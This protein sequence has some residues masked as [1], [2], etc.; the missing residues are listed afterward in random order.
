MYAVLDF[1]TRKVPN[2]AM[3]IGGIVG[4]GVVL[5]FGHIVEYAVLHLTA[6]LI[7]LILGCILFRIGALGGADVK[8][9]FTIAI[10]SP[11]IEFASWG[12]PIL[13]GILVVW[14]QLVIVLVV[15]YLISLRKKEETEIIP[16][17][18]ILFGAYLV[19]QLLAL[20]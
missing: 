5:Q 6:V 17:I 2:Q 3:L 9:L 4:L 20:F 12:T 18:P 1:R 10:I 15:G 13:E 11:G 16:L 8:T 7:V 14:L 19:L